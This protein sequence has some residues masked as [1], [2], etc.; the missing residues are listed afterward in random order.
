MNHG[1]HVNFAVD[2]AAG[3][4]KSRDPAINVGKSARII[5]SITGTIRPFLDVNVA[6]RPETTQPINAV[7]QK[8]NSGGG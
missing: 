7:L 4:R 1:S 8:Y 2:A 5:L 6:K 3:R